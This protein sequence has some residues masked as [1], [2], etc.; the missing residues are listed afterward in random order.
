MDALAPV[1]YPFSLFFTKPL[2]P[3][4]A[5]IIPYFI[6]LSLEKIK[7]KGFRNAT[8]TTFLD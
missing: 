5:S 7:K 4:K 3:Q 8:Y 2:I 6:S 1:N